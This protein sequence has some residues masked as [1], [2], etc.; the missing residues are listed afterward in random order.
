MPTRIALY[1]MLA[2]AASA[3]PYTAWKDYAGSADGMQYSALKQLTKA[4]AAQ[5]APAW[6][7]PAPGPASAF[8]PV[9]VDGVLYAL[10]ANRAIVAVDA[11]TGKPIWSHPVEG[12]PSERG[13]NYWESKDRADR[14]LIYTANSF[15]QEINARTGV[16]INTFGKDGRVDLRENLDR[17]PKSI[18]NIQRKIP[19]RVF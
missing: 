10:G 6:F 9:V 19:G 11:A 14:R 4:N 8:N 3:Q 12:N 2:A 13:I 15:L 18:R 17:D 16:T 7:L 1:A 5:L